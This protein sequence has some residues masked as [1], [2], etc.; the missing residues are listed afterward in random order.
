MDVDPHLLATDPADPPPGLGRL[1]GVQG[2]TGKDNRERRGN[3]DFALC[4]MKRASLVQCTFFG[5]CLH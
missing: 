1:A 3:P 4:E 5:G 2:A